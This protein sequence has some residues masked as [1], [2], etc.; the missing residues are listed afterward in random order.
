MDGRSNITLRNFITVGIGLILLLLLG[1]I[2]YIIIEGYAWLDAVYMTFIT[3]STVG[4]GEVRP[5]GVP[6]RVFTILLI[7]FGVIILAMLSATVTS[8][9]VKQELLTN[10]RRKRMKKKKSRNCADIPFCV[11]P[12]KPAKPSSMNF[13]RQRKNWW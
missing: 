9:F 3:F 2:G 6:G 7:L 1:T 5:L 10:F 8:L 11:A 4:F 13:N 12:V